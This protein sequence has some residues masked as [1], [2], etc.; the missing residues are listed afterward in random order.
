[1]IASMY[2]KTWMVSRCKWRA[3][4]NS[5]GERESIWFLPMMRWISITTQKLK[6]TSH[7]EMYFMLT[8]ALDQMATEP[9]NSTGTATLT[10]TKTTSTEKSYLICWERRINRYNKGE[11]EKER[12]GERG[13][14]K[15]IERIISEKRKEALFM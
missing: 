2:I 7:R 3:T 15:E 4:D 9:K 10:T 6:R 14:G 11:K 1:M 13:R 5:S 8:I 12:E